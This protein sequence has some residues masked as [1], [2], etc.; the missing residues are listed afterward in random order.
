MGGSI[1]DLFVDL[2]IAGQFIDLVV[3]LIVDPVVDI[4]VY[5]LLIFVFY[6]FVVIFFRFL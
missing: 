5:L 1:V 3:G 6:L 4:W 2:C